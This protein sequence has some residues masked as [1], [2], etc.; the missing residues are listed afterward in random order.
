MATARYQTPTNYDLTTTYSLTLNS[1]GSGS[2]AISTAINNSVNRHLFG[3][4]HL[5]ADWDTTGPSSYFQV[6]IWIVPSYDGG[7][8]YSDGST[9][10]TPTIPM[11]EAFPMRD[12]TTQQ[13]L[14]SPVPIMIPPTYFKV[15]VVN[16]TDQAMSSA[17]NALELYTFGYEIV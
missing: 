16:G 6:Q 17:G 7:T 4:F 15:L 12:V 1:L 2:R 13:E 9:T 5:S 11:A 10:V 3:A 14:V 8:T